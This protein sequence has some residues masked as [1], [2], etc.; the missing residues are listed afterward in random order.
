MN[1]DLQRSFMELPEVKTSYEK[2]VAQVVKTIH[3]HIDSR[4]MWGENS[5]IEWSGPCTSFH[6]IQ[7][8]VID[9]SVT[10]KCHAGKHRSVSIVER[11]RCSF[12]LHVFA[13][14]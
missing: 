5:A 12:V 13:I 1:K 10:I 3:E 11:L 2:L 8:P 7:I 4:A 9:V 6:S 14:N